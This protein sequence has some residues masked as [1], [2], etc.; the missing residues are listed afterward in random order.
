[1]YFRLSSV[2]GVVETGKRSVCVL[3]LNVHLWCAETTQRDTCVHAY[4]DTVSSF[5]IAIVEMAF[6]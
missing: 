5:L 6:G 2:F 3:N 4:R 1:M